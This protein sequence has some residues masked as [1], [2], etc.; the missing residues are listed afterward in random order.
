VTYYVALPFVRAEDGCAAG[1]ALECQSAPEANR[2]A[3]IMSRDL[4]N[5]GAVSF[6]RSGDPNLGSFADAKILKTFGD[7]PTNLDE[8]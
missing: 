8:L 7:V 2:K 5:T 3:E 4:A 6:M 1:Q